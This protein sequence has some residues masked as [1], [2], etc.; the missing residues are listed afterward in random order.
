MGRKTD[1]RTNKQQAN[2]AKE[3]F[4]KK[5]LD[6]LFARI[7]G[8]KKSPNERTRTVNWRMK[9]TPRQ[10]Q[11][12]AVNELMRQ[13]ESGRTVKRCRKLQARLRLHGVTREDLL[14]RMG[15]TGRLTWPEVE[16]EIQKNK[17]A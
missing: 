10:Y 13:W 7:G 15:Q 9:L 1:S 11:E 5:C 12:G 4:F 2:L 16:S 8:V 17:A 3:G 14:V 6:G